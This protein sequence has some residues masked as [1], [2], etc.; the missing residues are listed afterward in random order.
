V[1]PGIVFG[2][3]DRNVFETI[4]LIARF[5]VHPLPGYLYDPPL[6]LIYATDLVDLLIAVAG[7]GR[8]IDAT[9]SSCG[10][11]GCGYYFAVADEHPSYLEL[12]KSIAKAVGCRWLYPLRLPE[13]MIWLSGLGNELISRIRGKPDIFNVDKVREAFAGSWACSAELAQRE[14]GWKPAATLDQRLAETVDWYRRNR[15]L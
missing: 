5:G 9:R 10:E 1:R 3:R 14:L 15:W 8:R 6:S 2:P 13:P 7:R 12:G 4:A 11:A